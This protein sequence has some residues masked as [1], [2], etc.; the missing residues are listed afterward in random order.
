VKAFHH[1][2][3]ADLGLAEAFNMKPDL[4][5][6]VSDGEPTGAQPAAILAAVA[7]A[8]KELARP[9]PIHSVAYMADSGQKFM[10]DLAEK[11]GGM[12]REVNPSDVQ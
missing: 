10:K 2:T 4:I 7:E 3:R 1:G 8:Q 5:F 6:F 11:N 9:A 12:Y